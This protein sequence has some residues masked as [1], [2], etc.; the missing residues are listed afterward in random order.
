MADSNNWNRE[1]FS[2]RL[3][4]QITPLLSVPG[5]F[6]TLSRAVSLCCEEAERACSGRPAAC[7]AGCPHCCVLNVAALLPE[8]AVIAAWLNERLSRN[9]IGILSGLLDSHASWSRWMDDDERISRTAYCPFLDKDACCSIHPVRPLACRGVVSL[10]SS[11]CREAFTP[12]ISDDERGVPSDL[13]RRAVF[14]EA[15]ATLAHGLK[16]CGMDDKSI[17][18]GTGVLAFLVEPECMEGLLAGRKLPR[19]LWG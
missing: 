15:F 1:E 4:A 16:Q 3:S 8:A 10:D 2:H 12:V 18:L 14:D 7:F 11:R 17:E 6:E 9:E 19:K 13:L 5:D